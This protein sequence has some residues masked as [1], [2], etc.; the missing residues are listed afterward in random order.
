MQAADTT[1]VSAR[2]ENKRGLGAVYGVP[3]LAP[4][5]LRRARMVIRMSNIL[6]GGFGFQVTGLRAPGFEAA[7]L[8]LLRRGLAAVAT[9]GQF[10]GEGL[11][12]RALLLDCQ[13][14]DYAQAHLL[15]PS[16]APVAGN[17]SG[18][19]HSIELLDRK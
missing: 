8:V 14:D 19:L 1:A 5:G 7:E 4:T 11:L 10:N 17:P 6:G 13:F 15:P 9:I 18:H 16:R 12:E 3:A 2:F